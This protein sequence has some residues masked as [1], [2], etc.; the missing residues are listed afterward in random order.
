MFRTSAAA[1]VLLAALTSAC[2]NSGTNTKAAASTDPASGARTTTIV[3]TPTPTPGAEAAAASE[4]AAVRPAKPAAEPLMFVRAVQKPPIVTAKEW[5]SEP[6]SFPPEYVHTPRN[7]LIHHEGAANWKATD[8]PI[9]KIRNLQSWGYT[10]KKWND[11]PYHFIIAPDGRILEGRDVKYKPDTNT[12]FDT[13]GYINVELLGN[14]E[15]QRV[16]YKQLYATVMLV[17]WLSQEYRID[18]ATILT[19]KDAAPGQTDCPGKDFYQYFDPGPFRT[20]VRIAQTGKTPPVKLMP[21][22]PGGPTEIIPGED[23]P[24]TPTPTPAPGM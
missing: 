4:P 16:S 21:A 9:R 1:L 6:H 8:D 20:W 22:L 5:G 24:V 12:K 3:V 7:I 13:T 14:F 17:A 19:H 2:S 23:G 10:E 11:V 18:P 15:N